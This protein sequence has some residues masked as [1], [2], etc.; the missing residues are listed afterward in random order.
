MPKKK[1]LIIIAILLSTIPV[2]ANQALSVSQGETKLNIAPV[3]AVNS[4]T[5][6]ALVVWTQFKKSKPAYG[7]VL[8]ALLKR[9][10]VGKYSV[11]VRGRLSKKSGFNARPFPLYKSDQDQYLVV[12]DQAD[13]TNL[14]GRSDI[15]GRLVSANGALT[16]GVFTVLSTGARITSPQLYLRSF[17]EIAG[18]QDTPPKQIYI[19]ANIIQIDI[20]KIKETGLNW[21]MINANNRA[22][23][24][25]LI[26]PGGYWHSGTTII[27]QS[28]I[29]DG[30]G[31]VVDD[32][33]FL[34]VSAHVVQSSTRILLEPHLVVINRNDQ[35]TDKLSL[36]PK[37]STNPGIDTVVLPEGRDIL[38]MGGILNNNY[39]IQN[40]SAKIPL[41][42]DIPLLGQVFRKKGRFDAIKTV[43]FS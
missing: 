22:Q 9:N 11:A 24:M 30:P 17:A 42:G 34:T 35:I 38:V 6:D 23:D 4:V 36:G 20:N 14:L 16:G 25:E 12:W 41:L 10:V 2:Y 29:P 8:Y 40:T 26:L 13:P 33:V 21:G 1:L 28:I 5:G 39:Q 7:Q 37:G 27:P 3:F 19:A 43:W 32:K 31:R 18:N 15:R